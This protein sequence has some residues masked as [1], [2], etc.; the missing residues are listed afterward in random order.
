MRD[1]T[2]TTTSA[3]R[4]SRRRAAAWSLKLGPEGKTVFPLT[5]FDRDIFLYVPDAEMPDMPSALRFASA[6]T[7]RRRR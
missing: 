5:H 6:R 4:W 2:P 7:A 3:R 1:A